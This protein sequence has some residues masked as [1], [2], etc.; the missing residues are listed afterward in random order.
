[1]GKRDFLGTDPL[2]AVTRS[3]LTLKPFFTIGAGQG[4]RIRC[5]PMGTAMD[6]PTK[7]SNVIYVTHPRRAL[8]GPRAVSVKS[9]VRENCKEP[10]T[11][12]FRR[13]GQFKDH[14]SH[15]W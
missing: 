11:F 14:S 7:L 3:L 6:K 4:F 15:S 9:G 12:K 13:M 5:K 1:M 10:G 2:H 8:Y